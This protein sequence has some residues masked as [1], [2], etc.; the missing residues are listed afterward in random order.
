ML[1]GENKNVKFVI[2]GDGRE[3]DKLLEEIQTHEVEDMFVYETDTGYKMV[4]EDCVGYYTGL[5]KGG[6]ALICALPFSASA[7][8]STA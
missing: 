5:A 1:K 7:M 6:V 4:A 8:T 2:V 3:K